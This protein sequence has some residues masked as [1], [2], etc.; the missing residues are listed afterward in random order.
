MDKSCLCYKILAPLRSSAC[1][2]T[3]LGSYAKLVHHIQD[4]DLDLKKVVLVKFVS[5]DHVCVHL[6][7][8]YIIMTGASDLF[9]LI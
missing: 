1:A 3:Y 9:S 5:N 2:R 8:K 7:H 4:G 6:F